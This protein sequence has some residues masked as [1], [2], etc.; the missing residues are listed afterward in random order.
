VSDALNSYLTY[1]DGT[2]GTCGAAVAA[3]TWSNLGG[4]TP[5]GSVTV[6]SNQL[7]STTLNTVTSGQSAPYFQFEVK[8]K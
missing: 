2:A 7:T 6:V 8:V 1:C 3:G 5:S 4:S